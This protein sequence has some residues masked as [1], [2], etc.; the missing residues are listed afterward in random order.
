M[1]R[2]IV[3]DV[4]HGNCAIVQDGRELAV[5]DAPKT[6]VLPDCL[7]AQA[8]PAVRHLILSHADEDHIGGAQAL[9]AHE[10]IEIQ[11]LWI[12]PNSQQYSKTYL[13]LLTVARDRY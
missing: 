11:E 5:V 4:G 13:D 12:N 7:R 6:V 3:L 9:L 2:V 8:D 1:L 10:N